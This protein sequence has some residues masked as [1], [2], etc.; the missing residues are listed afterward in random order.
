M[1][2]WWFWGTLFKW[3]THSIWGSQESEPTCHYIV[4]IG[5]PQSSRIFPAPFPP[6]W[7]EF[8][9]LPWRKYIHGPLLFTKNHRWKG[10]DTLMGTHCTCQC[11]PLAPDFASSI[12]KPTIFFSRG[13]EAFILMWDLPEPWFTMFVFSKWVVTYGPWVYNYWG[14]K[15][16]PY[17]NLFGGRTGNPCVVTCRFFR[18]KLISWLGCS[19]PPTRR[20]SFSSGHP[21]P[22]QYG[23]EVSQSDDYCWPSHHHISSVFAYFYFSYFLH[24]HVQMMGILGL[25]FSQKRRVCLCER[26]GNA[27]EEDKLWRLSVAGWFYMNIFV[28]PCSVDTFSNFC[29]NRCKGLLGQRLTSYEG[30]QVVNK[31]W[32]NTLTTYFKS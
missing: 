30:S 14:C 27:S 15:R 16:Q 10:E 18:G 9:N 6:S 12:Q 24:S 19:P 4:E 20:R 32:T 13:G 26:Q 11:S 29:K 17:A 28:K 7:K 2:D 5:N 8:S 25:H 23:G 1:V 31:F 21:Q 3:Q 22:S